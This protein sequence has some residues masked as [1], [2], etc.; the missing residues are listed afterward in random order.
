MSTGPTENKPARPAVPA[1]LAWLGRCRDLARALDGIQD[2]AADLAARAAG[3]R[4]L[5]ERACRRLRLAAEHEPKSP[6]L[7]Q[8]AALWWRALAKVSWSWGESPL[9]PNPYLSS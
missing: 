8:M 6:M 5:V 4:V 3:N 1:V 9:G 7:C 2:A